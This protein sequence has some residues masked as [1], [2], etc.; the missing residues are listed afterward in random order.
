MLAY[1]LALA[2]GLG[3]F[4]LYMVA[5]FLP[6]VHRKSDFIWSGVGLFYALILWVCAGRITGAVLLG[7]M[8][9]VALLGWF[10]WQVLTLR[11]SLTP[12]AQQTPLPS[13]E[14][15]PNPATQL[16]GRGGL[17]QFPGKVTGL[18]AK[19]KTAPVTQPSSQPK[20]ET[21]SPPPAKVRFADPADSELEVNEAG[22]EAPA[23]AS[24][25]DTPPQ[26][27]TS[28]STQETITPPVAPIAPPPTLETVT[29]TQE[30]P[31]VPAVSEVSLETPTVTESQPE[32]DWENEAEPAEPPQTPK[33]AV[34]PPAAK[35]PKKSGGFGNL[36]ANLKNRLGFGGFSKRKTKQPTQPTKVD[37]PAPVSETETATAPLSDSENLDRVLEAELA[38]VAEEVATETTLPESPETATAETSEVALAQ[39]EEVEPLPTAQEALAETPSEAVPTPETPAESSLETNPIA[40][41]DT[42]EAN[43]QTLLVEITNIEITPQTE[44]SQLEE[45]TE[46]QNV[47]EAV[48]AVLVEITPLDS[49]PNP[50]GPKQVET[51]QQETEAKPK[52]TSLEDSTKA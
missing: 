10:G 17:S 32:N 48:E 9:S 23:I 42:L 31:S 36:F 28:P 21:V 27:L 37:V 39:S 8:A 5:F 6:E 52:N 40:A 15:L 13:P 19:K 50:P 22:T 18:F 41:G 26:S 3:S 16:A 14:T 43:T 49:S 20:S 45:S 4:A 7:Q 33:P 2:V 38:A 11:R 24:L 30:T 29:D 34:T 46:Q 47:P 25:E 51:P 44:P 12:I 35:T 1:I